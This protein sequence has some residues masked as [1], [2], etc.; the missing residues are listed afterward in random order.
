VAR[1]SAMV[2]GNLP[3]LTN[4]GST[5]LSVLVDDKDDHRPSTHNEWSAFLALRAA[6]PVGPLESNGEAFG[7]DTPPHL[8]CIFCIALSAKPSVHRRCELL[9]GDKMSARDPDDRVI[10]QALIARRKHNT[11]SSCRSTLNDSE[12]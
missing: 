3:I 11:G 12:S 2:L 6:K 8:I 4:T 9:K 1:S 5:D 10:D 7:E